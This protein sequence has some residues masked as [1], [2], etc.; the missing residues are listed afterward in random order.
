MNVYLAWL[1]DSIL[2]VY[3]TQ[4]AAWDATKAYESFQYGT[5]RSKDVDFSPHCWRY[6]GKYGSRYYHVSEYT[7][8]D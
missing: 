3:S 1:N 4:Q 8:K 7:V 5:D 2:G 6:D